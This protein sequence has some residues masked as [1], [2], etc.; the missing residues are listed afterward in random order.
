MTFV[1]PDERVRKD[2]PPNL[3]L[4][5]WI[6][7]QFPAGY[8]GY[9]VD[10]GASDGVSVS[11]SYGLEQARW[12]VLCIEPNPVFHEKLKKL[13]PFVMACACDAQAGTAEFHSFNV[14]PEAYSA[15]R[16]TYPTD[17][18]AKD[19]HWTTFPVTVKTLEQCLA[20]AQFPQLD[21]LAIDVEGNE[22]DV[23]NG[24]DLAKWHPKVILAEAWTEGSLD[25]Y[26]GVYDYGRKWRT[27]HNDCY[28]R[29]P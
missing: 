25:E 23:L 6:M 7:R 19:G 17:F 3:E 28:V 12:T 21:A 24:I 4:S 13:R 9:A 15:L 8:Q 29:N 20:E 5:A 18:P 2:W 22:M 27:A 1:V 10:V 11:S 26:L 14:N 16:P